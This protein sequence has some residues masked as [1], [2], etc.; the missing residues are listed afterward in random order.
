MALKDL[1]SVLDGTISLP[2]G[3]KTYKVPPISIEAGLRFQELL[4]IAA[5]AK[6]AEDT[7]TE[8]ELTDL[9]TQVLTDQQERDLYSE[10]LGDVYEELI[11]DGVSFDELKMAAMYVLIKSVQSE[12]TAEAFWNNG[13]KAPARNRAER[14]TATRTRTG[15]ATTT[16]KPASRTGTTT[17][18][19]TRKEVA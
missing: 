9:D 11:A 19:A 5:K 15:A 10:A 4:G 13:G 14:R 7:G 2:I 8:F 3:G 6:K 12:E 16:R 17:R 18:K 1:R